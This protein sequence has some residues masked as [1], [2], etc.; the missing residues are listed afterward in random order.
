MPTLYMP[1]YGTMLPITPPMS[2]PK[3]RLKPP[4]TQISPTTPMQ[5][6]FWIMID[7]MSR[8]LTRPP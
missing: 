4:T 7:S 2:G 6:K 1:K 3:T 8:C 5:T